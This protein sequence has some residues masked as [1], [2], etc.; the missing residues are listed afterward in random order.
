MPKG[1]V[2]ICPQMINGKKLYEDLCMSL[3]EYRVILNNGNCYIDTFNQDGELRKYVRMTVEQLDE[4][5]LD[6]YVDH[7][8]GSHDLSE[9]LLNSSFIYVTYS[10]FSFLK[11]VVNRLL[12]IYGTMLNDFWLDDDYENILRGKEILNYL[13]R[14]SPVP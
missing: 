6:T 11:I 2:I 12:L 3:S 14:D 4:M 13:S 9:N 1:V 8:S 10:H 5:I 7:Y